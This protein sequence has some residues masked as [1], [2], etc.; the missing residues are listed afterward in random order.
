MF[1]VAAGALL[2]GCFFG[3][4]GIEAP[5]P[6]A[7][8][9]RAAVSEQDVAYARTF[10]RA[11]GKYLTAMNTETARDPNLFSD[12]KKLLR[13]AAPILDTFGKELDKAKPPKDMTNFHNALVERVKL[14]AKKA[15]SG[16]VVTPQELANVSKGSP[17]PPET[18]RARI[19]E[20]AGQLPE[21]LNSGGADA[22]FGAPG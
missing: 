11:F 21:C 13:L 6:G 15:K 19:A 10:C 14:V 2:S 9:T 20:A 18:V 8:P 22:L 7:T 16:Q 1:V 5:T 4:D 3:G 12:Q 17:L